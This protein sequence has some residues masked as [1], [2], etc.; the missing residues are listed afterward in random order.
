MTDDQQV[1]QS[2]NQVFL[3]CHRLRLTYTL[4][5]TLLK[6]IAR[7]LSYPG[8]FRILTP[9]PQQI[10]TASYHILALGGGAN[11]TVYYRPGV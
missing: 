6:P 10:T 4:S 5:P 11:V 1:G 7:N 8:T 9:A 2:Q 3:H